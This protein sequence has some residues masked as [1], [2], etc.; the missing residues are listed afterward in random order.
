MWC[1]IVGLIGLLT[2]SIGAMLLVFKA[3]KSEDQIL[4]EATPMVP[5]LPAGVETEEMWKEALRKL[6]MVQALLRQSQQAK[7]GF[8]I[9]AVGF[10]F[11]FVG[12]LALLINTQ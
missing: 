3:V 1:Y 5:A 2:S 9:L 10:I 11:Q 8:C 12:A 6:P 4:H 7:V